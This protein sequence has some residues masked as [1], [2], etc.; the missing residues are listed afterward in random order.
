M[1]ASNSNGTGPYGPLTAEPRI[2]TP[3]GPGETVHL[4][5]AEVVI[6]SVSKTFRRLG[7]RSA[8]SRIGEV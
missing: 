2:S 5:G 6:S 8:A 4:P 1:G 7:R 3:G